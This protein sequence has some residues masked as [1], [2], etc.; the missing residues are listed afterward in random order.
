MA[1]A[2]RAPVGPQRLDRGTTPPLGE[3]GRTQQR[4]GKKRG[5]RRKTTG[6]CK[7][8]RRWKSRTRERALSISWHTVSRSPA[9]R[10]GRKRRRAKMPKRQ[11]M[12]QAHGGEAPGSARPKP[13]PGFEPRH[14]NHTVHT[15]L[16]GHALAVA[17][18]AV[19]VG[20]RSR[21]FAGLAQH[22]RRAATQRD[23]H[24]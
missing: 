4:S 8:K 12:P 1:D 2:N 13:R 14:H 18:R 19:D 10:T 5:K 17:L 24:S 6:E 20:A 22:S 9:G 16:L 21:T 15:H 11:Q 7:K 3:R 23:A